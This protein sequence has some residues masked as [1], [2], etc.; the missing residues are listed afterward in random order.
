[1]SIAGREH[2]TPEKGLLFCLPGAARQEDLANASPRELVSMLEKESSR[3]LRKLSVSNALVFVVIVGLV[4]SIPR[5]AAAYAVLTHQAIID[6]SWNHMLKPRLHERFPQASDDELEA[7]KA[8]AYGGGIIQD[9]GYF[10]FCNEFY[11]DLAHY[12]RTGDFVAA[13][14]RDA[15]TLNEYAFALGA[16]EH[17]VADSNG[18]PLATN[19]AV[20]IYF[21]KL[22]KKYGSSVTYEQ[23]ETAHC[24]AESGFDVAE[25]ARNHYPSQTYHQRKG[26][27][28]AKDLL[29][30]AFRETYGLELRDVLKHEN[31]AIS[32]Y[33]DSILNII[34]AITRIA[35]ETKSDQ[36]KAAHPELAGVYCESP[37]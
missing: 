10:P 20:A 4:L 6:F 29:E 8:Y 3:Q 21:D 22:A 13:L 34:P 2:R 36:I 17:Y 14:I 27:K 16:L 15:K 26:F 30:R 32:S 23:N 5:S 28:V 25:V 18:H 12:V 19:K 24:R 11:S 7:A 37:A 35:W 9:M 33:S 1:V 31:L